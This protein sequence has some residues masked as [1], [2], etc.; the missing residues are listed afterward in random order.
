MNLFRLLSFFILITL[1]SYL[2][3]GVKISNFENNTWTVEAEVQ[4]SSS[5]RAKQTAISLA[6]NLIIDKHL[7]EH[8]YKFI[9]DLSDQKAKSILLSFRIADEVVSKGSYSA[10]FYIAIHKRE[11]DDLINKRKGESL[12]EKIN[13]I[14]LVYN[15]D[16]KLEVAHQYRTDRIKSEI[17]DETQLIIKTELSEKEL[18]IVNDTVEQDNDLVKLNKLISKGN[19]QVA[20]V[21]IDGNNF[22]T[23]IAQDTFS[24][25]SADKT[26]EQI[27][28]YLTDNI[29]TEKINIDGASRI[30]ITIADQF[31]L[32][33]ILEVVDKNNNLDVVS[34]EGSSITVVDNKIASNIVATNE[35][36]AMLKDSS[37]I[38]KKINRGY[39]N[40]IIAITPR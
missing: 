16:G 17:V 12:S 24:F 26:V 5:T 1:S 8:K 31:A 23:I 4:D 32:R 20:V 37:V 33:P 35:I 30:K 3:A 13:I 39:N 29:E 40:E 7:E 9:K 38:I 6:T 14:P 27:R 10:T 19:S 36:I 11:F 18:K 22:K 28:S 34:I 25:N 21:I 2:S 15:S